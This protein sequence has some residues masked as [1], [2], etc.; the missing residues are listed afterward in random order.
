MIWSLRDRIQAHGQSQS[1][2]STG[3]GSRSGLPATP[4]RGRRPPFDAVTHPA[5][6]Y[7][8]ANNNPDLRG[9]RSGRC[10]AL[11]RGRTVAEDV[12]ARAA[13]RA[14]SQRGRQ[15]VQVHRRAWAARAAVICMAPAPVYFST[16]HS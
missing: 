7:K 16:T 9:K 10:T 11:R 6:P 14:V 2:W 5:R 12:Q 1:G 3:S 15:I 8:S 4:A 13:D